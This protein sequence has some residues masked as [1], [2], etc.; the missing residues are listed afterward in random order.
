VAHAVGPG[1][2][3]A[4][5]PFLG[6]EDLAVRELALVVAARTVAEPSSTAI[7]RVLAN[8]GGRW[9]AA[10]ATAAPLSYAASVCAGTGASRA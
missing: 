10:V 4:R 9:L 2:D 5:Q 7:I 8:I 6:D 1:R 3:R